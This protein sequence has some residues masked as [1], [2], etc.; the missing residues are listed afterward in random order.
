MEKQKTI[1]APVLIKK[2]LLERE[3]RRYMREDFL[4]GRE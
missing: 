1:E 4:T 2:F 3:S